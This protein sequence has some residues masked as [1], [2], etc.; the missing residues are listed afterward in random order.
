MISADKNHYQNLGVTPSATP[1][2]IK[3]A[4]RK[5]AKIY[6]PDHN[7]KRRTAEAR[8]K[9]LQNAYDTL[10]DP[11]KRQ[12]YDQLL[13]DEPAVGIENDESVAE[14]WSWTRWEPHIF[15]FIVGSVVGAFCGF[16]A[17]LY[18]YT[19]ALNSN[20]WGFVFLGGGALLGGFAASIYFNRGASS[21]RSPNAR[22]W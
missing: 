4:Y 21:S 22:D 2:E 17:L 15:P 6:H 12:Q 13:L 3:K 14:G 16:E 5:L 18:A 20:I 19:P 9:L 10:S 7:P 1:D 8:F 11:E